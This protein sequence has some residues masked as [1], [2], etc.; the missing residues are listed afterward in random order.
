MFSLVL[1]SAAMSQRTALYL[2]SLSKNSFV[3]ATSLVLQQQLPIK[4]FT[5]VQTLNK[6]NLPSRQCPAHPFWVRANTR[7]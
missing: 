7:K 3:G 2:F 6:S 4:I 5:I 1:L